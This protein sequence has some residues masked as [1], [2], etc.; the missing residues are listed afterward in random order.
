MGWSGDMRIAYIYRGDDAWGMYGVARQLGADFMPQKRKG[1]GSK[2][3]VELCGG[4]AYDLIIV[5]HG[6]FREFMIEFPERADSIRESR[7]PLVIYETNDSTLLT[8]RKAL[9]WPSVRLVL[10]RSVLEPPHLANVTS[11]RF[12]LK[13]LHDAGVQ[14]KRPMYKP[15]IPE[16]LLT[17][18]ELDKV[19]PFA[20]FGMYASIR[21]IKGDKRVD[22]VTRRPTPV[23]YAGTVSYKGSEIQTH[24]TLC[25]RACQKI[26]NGIG[27]AGRPLGLGKYRDHLRRSM[28]VPCPY[29]WGETTYREFESW[30]SGAIVI[31]PP[32]D[33]IRCWP[34]DMFEHSIRCKPDFSNLA[35][36]VEGFCSES[37]W[38]R[39]EMIAAARDMA[40]RAG[41]T[42][43]LTAR[44]R[45]LI[46]EK[47]L[48]TISTSP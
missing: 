21:P 12:H 44:F 6:I 11:E 14:A 25:V 10:K 43:L 30:L 35:E 48:C 33:H 32:V 31:K 4:N 7:I 46:E 13:I 45:E 39:Q 24:R 38:N 9:P 19:Q 22:L 42:D 28:C 16:R 47:V 3:I 8:F 40:I 2:L 27:V 37:D 18:E 5:N 26:E 41:R 36:I 23:F 17:P 15:D 34:E 29:G 1:D 20:S